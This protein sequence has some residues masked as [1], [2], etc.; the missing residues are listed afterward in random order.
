MEGLQRT[1]T[2]GNRVIYRSLQNSSVLSGFGALRDPTCELR[3][4][5]VQVVGSRAQVVRVSSTRG[6]SQ[7][8]AITYSW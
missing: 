2:L 1:S 4:L 8:A 3:L 5:D 6:R 7:V